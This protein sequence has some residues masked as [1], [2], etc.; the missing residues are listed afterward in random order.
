MADAAI[1]RDGLV[2]M[3]ESLA[4]VNAG[5]G[6]RGGWVREW[7]FG[8]AQGSILSRGSEMMPLRLV[9]EAPFDCSMAGL[10]LV[11]DKRGCVVGNSNKKKPTCANPSG[12]R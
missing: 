4:E 1:E 11:I 9:G 5:A 3:P 12:D 10:W 2:V 8:V 6:A 7:T